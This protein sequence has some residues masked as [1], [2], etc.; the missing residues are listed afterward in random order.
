MKNAVTLR[1]TLSGSAVLVL[2]KGPSL[3]RQAYAKAAPEHVVVSI[4]QA[5]AAFPCDV[6]FFI[7]IEPLFEILDHLLTTRAVV[8]LPWRPNQRTWRKSR[9]R[10]MKETLADLV[11]NEPRLKQLEEQDRLRFFHTVAPAFGGEGS[12]F[13]PNLVS[14]SSLLQLLAEAGVKE[15]KTLGIDGGTGYSSDIQASKVK[16]QLQKGYGKQFP[17]LRTIALSRGL[18]MERANEEPINIYV[19]CEPAQALAARVLEH[20]ILRNTNY[21]VRIKRLDQCVSR[22]KSTVPGRTPFS[23]QRFWIPELNQFHGTAIYFDSDMLVYHDIRELLAN[24]DPDAAVSSAGIRPGS[25]RRPQY[26]VMVIDCER[27]HW[28]AELIQRLASK[29]YESTMFQFE[30]EPSK[31]MC[32]PHQWNS[33]EYIDADTRLVHFTDMDIQPWISTANV[34]APQWMDALFA[35]MNDKFVSFDDLVEDVQ[36]GWIRPGLLWQAEYGERDPQKIPRKQRALDSLYT[37]PHTVARFSKTN[38]TAVR[39]SLAV[40]KRILHWVR[41]QS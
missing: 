38:N 33:L 7:D 20:S 35:A 5:A 23:M 19:G 21:P 28:N 30:F 12:F 39:A 40:S 1:E 29:E 37:P 3:T 27:A 17:I 24:R 15:V 11:A 34:L 4:N 10:P 31:D 6:A 18:R 26:S 41:K 2:G 14:L 9:S 22:D 13:P 8:I 16:T 25:N 32:I 36:R